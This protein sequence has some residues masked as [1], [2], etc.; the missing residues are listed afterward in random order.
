MV[1]LVDSKYLEIVYSLNDYH[2]V[3]KN[4]NPDILDFIMRTTLG[5]Q[6]FLIIL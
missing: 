4:D 5:V 3:I 1:D 2:Q 6:F